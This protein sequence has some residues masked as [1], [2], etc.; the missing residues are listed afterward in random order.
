MKSNDLPQLLRQLA[1]EFDGMTAMSVALSGS[2]ARGDHRTGRSGHITSDLDLVPVVVAAA[3]ASAARAGL[4]PILQRLADTFRIEATAAVT[5][6]AAFRA[7]GHAPYR[8]SMR[9]DWLCDGLGLGPRAFDL[10]GPDD[11]DPHAA[12]AWAMQPVTYYL[13]KATAQ[14]PQT[15]LLK[16]RSA[17]M[18]LADTFDL[19][20]VRSSLDDLPRALR[21]LIVER[22]IAPLSSTARYLDGPTRPGAAQAVRDAVFAENQGLPFADSAVAAWPSDL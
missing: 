17:A 8:T 13:A 15:N 2:L 5:T 11:G 12:L 18:G 19:E 9:P 22:R 16:A 20:G 21:N 10:P 6:L 4:Q 3:D 7:A 1:R 14:D